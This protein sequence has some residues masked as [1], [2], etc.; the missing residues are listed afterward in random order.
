VGCDDPDHPE[1]WP[2]LEVELAAYRIASCAVTNADFA[3]FVTA[4]GHRTGFARR[5]PPAA[6]G[7]TWALPFG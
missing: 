7:V 4:T 1:E 3:E 2:V 5:H 6:A